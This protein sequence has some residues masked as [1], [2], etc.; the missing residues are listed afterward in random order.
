MGVGLRILGSI[1]FTRRGAAAIALAQHYR[2]DAE[3]L[4]V[5]QDSFDEFSSIE[6]NSSVPNCRGRTAVCGEAP[7]KIEK[8]PECPRY[9]HP[10]GKLLRAAPG[11]IGSEH[12]ERDQTRVAKFCAGCTAM[13]HDDA[14]RRGDPNNLDV[15]VAYPDYR[16]SRLKLDC[17]MVFST[18]VLVSWIDPAEKIDMP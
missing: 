16:A 7:A 17:G 14:E 12:R 8:R 11:K 5:R 9:H 2:E 18:I 10:Q 6:V 1:H 4:N 13:K 3:A 15:L